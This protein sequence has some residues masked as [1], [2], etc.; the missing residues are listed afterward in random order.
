MSALQFVNNHILPGAYSLLPAKMG[1]KASAAMLLA[2]GTIESDFRHRR[3]IR[4][5][6]VGYWQFEQGGGIRGVMTHPASRQHATDAVEKLNYGHVFTDSDMYE[7][8]PHNDILAAV[9]ARLLLW[10]LPQVLPQL[11]EPKNA[12]EQ[13]LDAWRPG[14]PAP[15]EKWLPAFQEAWENV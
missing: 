7:A 3:Q 2:I 14:K 4:G 9:F 5:P 15:Y 8:I 1:A 12:Y 6:A 10:T 13:Y 11:T